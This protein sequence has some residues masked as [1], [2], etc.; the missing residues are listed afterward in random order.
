MEYMIVTLINDNKNLTFYI[1]NKYSVYDVRYFKKYKEYFKKIINK[2]KR[3]NGYVFEDLYFDKTKKIDNEI[4]LY[5]KLKN[6]NLEFY[7]D[8][9]YYTLLINGFLISSAINNKTITLKEGI[10]L[11]KMLFS[12]YKKEIRD[13]EVNSIFF[14]NEENFMKFREDYKMYG[15]ESYE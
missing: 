3:Y 6:L 8:G 10:M 9:V 13:K 14:D 15:V 5:F 7:K 2:A 11:N 1:S 12:K 4:D